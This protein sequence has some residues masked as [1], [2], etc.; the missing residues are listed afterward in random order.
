PAGNKKALDL[1][2]VL[3]HHESRDH[4]HEQVHTDD[5]A[6]QQ[7]IEVCHEL[8]VCLSLATRE[9][10]RILDLEISSTAEIAGAK[11]RRRS[12][13]SLDESEAFTA[14][15]K[16]FFNSVPK[17]TLRIPQAIALSRSSAETPEPPCSTRGVF[18]TEAFISFNRPKSSLTSPL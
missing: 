14:F 3:S 2:D 4:G 16:A 12:M 13:S 8:D 9:Q 1:A 15:V 6:V 5:A 18:G 7:P 17:F 10:I 11:V